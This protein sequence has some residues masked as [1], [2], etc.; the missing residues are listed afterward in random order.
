MLMRWNY[1]RPQRHWNLSLS[2]FWRANQHTTWPEVHLSDHRKIKKLVKEIT[3]KGTS[4][5]EFAKLSVEQLVFNYRQ[6]T[7]LLYENGYQ[8]TNKLSRTSVASWTPR[9]SSAQRTN[10]KQ[11]DKPNNSIARL[12]PHSD[13]ISKN[14]LVIMIYTP[15]T[16]MRP[17]HQNTNFS[18]DLTVRTL[19][20]A[21][22]GPDIC[23]HTVIVSLLL[24]CLRKSGSN[25]WQSHYRHTGPK[26]GG[27]STLQ[28]Q[29]LQ[30]CLKDWQRN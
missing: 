2:T 5:G 4:D 22:S 15:R 17:Q 18:F 16:H 13:H 8:L 14:T 24:K 23:W 28:A 7:E 25:R 11:M 19:P 20:L 10:Q 6:S 29:S 21:G 30:Q 3:M 12:P 26:Q 1:Y 9:V 27:P